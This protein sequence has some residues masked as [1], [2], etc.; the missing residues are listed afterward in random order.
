MHG[1]DE[2]QHTFWLGREILGGPVAT[3]SPEPNTQEL[4]AK[5]L[6]VWFRRQRLSATQRVQGMFRGYRGTSPI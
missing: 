1:S 6:S 2:S 3:Q 5:S 4:P